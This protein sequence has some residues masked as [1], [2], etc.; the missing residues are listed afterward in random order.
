MIGLVGQ[1][2]ASI[3]QP[4]VQ[5]T[6]EQ[7]PA[8]LPCG[9][10]FQLVLVGED[11]DAPPVDECAPRAARDV[12]FP[13]KAAR[14]GQLLQGGITAQADMNTRGCAARRT[15]RRRRTGLGI[16]PIWEQGDG[17]MMASIVEASVPR[18][19]TPPG[20]LVIS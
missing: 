2:G 6:A 16:P 11:G 13:A 1:R 5:R 8:E 19:V 17:C 12:I 9:A 10:L 15:R 3:E 14:P 7:S 4:E 20:G 18:A